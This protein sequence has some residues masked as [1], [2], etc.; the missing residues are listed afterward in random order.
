MGTE[1][2]PDSTT[3]AS[4]LLIKSDDF[5]T[6]NAAMKGSFVGVFYKI[7]GITKRFRPLIP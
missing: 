3:V 6:T 5:L 2:L 7:S 4:G 1:T